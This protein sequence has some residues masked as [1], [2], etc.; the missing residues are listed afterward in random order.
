MLIYFFDINGNVSSMIIILQ[1]FILATS[2]WWPLMSL[3][4]KTLTQSQKIMRKETLIFVCQR[5]I[6]CGMLFQFLI[7]KICVIFIPF[8]GT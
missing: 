1:P 5:V 3:K 2:P 6:K 4:V 8:S 7:G